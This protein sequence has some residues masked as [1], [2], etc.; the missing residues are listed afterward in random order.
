MEHVSKILTKYNNV[1]N[2]N[3]YNDNNNVGKSKYALDKT[4][5]IPSNEESQLAEEIANFFND[6]ENFAFYY[7]VVKKLSIIRAMEA[8]A[9][10]KDEI[11]Q[12]EGTKYVIRNPKKYFAWKYK[13]GLY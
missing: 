11:Q 10:I 12:K 7:S 3:K 6:T 1:I 9:D 2:D 4:K 13:K 8:F 5:F